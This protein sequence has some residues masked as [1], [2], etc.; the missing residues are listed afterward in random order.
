MN[1]SAEHWAEKAENGSYYAIKL[2]LF[3]YRFGGKWLIMLCLAPV[4]LYFF[5][6][7]NTARHASMHF[8]RQLHQFKGADSPFSQMPGYW[9]SYR[10]FWQFAMAA[11]AKI[12][13]WSGRLSAEHDVRRSG[14][15]NFGDIAAA[16]KGGV[17]I[18]SHLGNTEVCRA[19]VRSRYPTRINVLVFTRHAPAFNK[20]LKQADQQVELNLIQVDTFTPDLIIMLKQRVEKG[21]FV[22]IVGDRIS[23]TT[24]ERVVWTE[25]IGKPAPFAIGPWILAS[26]LECPV[27]LMFCLQEQRHYHLIFES[28]AEQIHLP[29]KTRQQA[30]QDLICRYAERLEQQT[31]RYPLQWFNFYDFWQLPVVQHNKET[32]SDIRSKSIG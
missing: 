26:V 1:K 21:E 10:H 23:V 25:F 9:L 12:D 4:L 29:R 32:S 27:Y 22:V 2:L 30:L 11:L 5:I 18:S 16:G 28:F 13:A 15:I 17:L 6:K 20:V 31:C 7:D 19:L 24:P 3:F 8:L 14:D